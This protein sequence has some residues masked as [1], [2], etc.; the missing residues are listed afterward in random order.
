MKNILLFI[1]ASLAIS[2]AS[3]KEVTQV[4]KKEPF[5]GVVRFTGTSCRVNI[6][7][8][9]NE[10]PEYLGK[11]VYALNL[12]TKFQKN[13]LK[14]NFDLVPSKALTPDGCNASLVATVINVSVLK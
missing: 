13:G 7:I 10:N 1:V 14:I 8:L 6:E 2:C 4:K 12:E 9:T 11:M 5:T 3:K